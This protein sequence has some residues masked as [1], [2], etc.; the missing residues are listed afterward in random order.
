[1]I[2]REKG[3]QYPFVVIHKQENKIIGSTRLL[4]IHPAHK[5]LEIGWTW[6][7][8]G[9]WASAINLECKLLL[10]TY[11]FENFKANRVQLKTDENNL[12]SRKA[13]AKI[14]AHY[15]GILRNDQVRDNGTIRSTAYFSILNSEW[16]NV[17][18]NLSS[19]FQDKK[20]N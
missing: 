1:L 13:I 17:K 19:L 14:G 3:T 2:E 18:S 6:L 4:D 9:Y 11:C 16:E 5:K 7:H 8:P 12:R 15:E 20:R 10:L